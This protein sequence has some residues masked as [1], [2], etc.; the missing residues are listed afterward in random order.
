MKSYSMA[1][2][3]F[4]SRLTICRLSLRSPSAMAILRSFGSACLTF[5]GR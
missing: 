5:A 4:D 2:P 3:W 1:H